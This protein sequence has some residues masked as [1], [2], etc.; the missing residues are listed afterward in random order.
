MYLNGMGNVFEDDASIDPAAYDAA[1]SNGWDW[2]PTM[3]SAG[4]GDIN[5]T[6][7]INTALQTWTAKNNADTQLEIA[8]L[9]AQQRALPYSTVPGY[10]GASPV[11]SRSG[12][13]PFPGAAGSIGGLNYSTLAIVAVLIAGGYFLLKD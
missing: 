10:Y 13:S 7:A 5:W 3:P 8:K 11:Y 2:L 1:N 9:Q 6:G 4:G 12:L